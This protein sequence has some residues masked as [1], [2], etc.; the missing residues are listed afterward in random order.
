MK[1]TELATELFVIMLAT[2]I[3]LAHAWM[4]PFNAQAQEDPCRPDS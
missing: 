3:I 1:T 4:F 2:G